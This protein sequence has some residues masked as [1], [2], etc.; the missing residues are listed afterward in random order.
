MAFIQCSSKLTSLHVR[1]ILP[2][3]RFIKPGFSDC[4]LRVWKSFDNA[5][6]FHARVVIMCFKIIN[7]GNVMYLA[8]KYMEKY[9]E[10][11]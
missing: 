4:D 7:L 6:K 1:L 2:D 8:T 3:F 9:V 10:L 11:V 5:H